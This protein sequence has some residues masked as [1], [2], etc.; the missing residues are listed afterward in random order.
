MTAWATILLERLAFTR[1]EALSLA[2]CYVNYTSTMRGISLGIIPKEEKDRA[3][4]IVGP[5]QPHFEL[6][7]SK[8]P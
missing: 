5:N 8:S 4:H 3:V 2:H 1:A 6:M 7:E